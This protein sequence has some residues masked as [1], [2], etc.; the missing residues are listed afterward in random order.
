MHKIVLVLSE[1]VLGSSQLHH[2]NLP[3]VSLNEQCD[4]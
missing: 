4:Q 3:M 2:K 1:K